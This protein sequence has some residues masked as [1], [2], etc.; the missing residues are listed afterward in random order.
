MIRV[1]FAV[2]LTL[3]VALPLYAQEAPVDLNTD[4]EKISYVFGTSVG[5][6][7]KNQGID[8]DMDALIQGIRD[9]LEGEEIRLTTEEQQLIVQKF[10]AEQEKR[11]AVDALGEDAWKI[12]L[13]KPKIMSFDKGKRYYWILSTNKGIIKIELMPDVA[14]MHV[15]STIYLTQK[16]FYD[17]LTFHRIIPG[18]MAQGGCPFGN[19]TGDPG[20][21]Y[22]G[23]FSDDVKHNK[24][25]MVS[26]ANAGSGTDGSQFFITFASASHLDGKHTI[27][28][29]VVDGKD[30]VQK[31]ETYGSSDGTPKETIVIEHAAIEEE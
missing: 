17:G 18:F 6:S 12:Q 30:V 8:P 20:Y 19:G 21:K 25:Y 29:E 26:M 24:P 7:L 27:F 23:E 5:G 3:T 9:V 2:L 28:G 31:L 11:A 15:T 10:R 1:F 13:E 22:D 4:Q 16:G 14:P